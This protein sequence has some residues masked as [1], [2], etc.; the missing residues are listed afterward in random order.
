M[1][2]LAETDADPASWHLAQSLD[3]GRS[4]QPPAS[5]KTDLGWRTKDGR[6]TVEGSFVRSMILGWMRRASV[7]T[8]LGAELHTPLLATMKPG[9]PLQV[10]TQQFSDR[11]F[12]TG[13]QGD[14][15]LRWN[16]DPGVFAALRALRDDNT[17]PVRLWEIGPAF[18]KN[19]SGERRG[20]QRMDEFTLHDHHALLPTSDAALAEYERLLFAQY[21][22]IA[23]WSTHVALRFYAQPAGV[24]HAIGLARE[25][26]TRTGHFV[27]VTE[28]GPTGTYW[29][30]G[31]VF[32]SERQYRM[33]N[34]QFDN[35]NPQRFGFAG[36]DGERVLLHTSLGTVERMMLVSSNE[37][38]HV[39][40]YLPL[41]LAPIQLTLVIA[42]GGTAAEELAC[43]LRAAGV[44]CESRTATNGVGKELADSRRRMVPA[45]AVCHPSALESG[46]IDLEV[47]GVHH[48]GL[49]LTAVRD[50]LSTAERASR[51][52]T[53][54]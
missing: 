22:L 47:A 39:D 40:G 50:R 16:A 19:Q 33:F 53:T 17:D 7:D 36:A 5:L 24:P 20:I 31:H 30:F 51:K 38:A 25:F 18:R 3:G 8:L 11:I 29:P 2:T 45:R 28:S 27:L 32:F 14:R 9:S 4:P 12:M 15:A 34:T 37:S 1:D 6:W 41:W 35:T 23:D 44:R 42:D 52:D 26:S 13:S 49:P 54:E 43:T 48:R 21:A 10:L 46:V